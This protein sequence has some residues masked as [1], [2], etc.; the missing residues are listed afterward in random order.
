MSKRKSSQE[1]KKI[2]LD[3]ALRIVIEQGYNHTGIQEIVDAVGIPKGSF[4]NYFDSKETFGS[5]LVWHYAN[6]ILSQ[7]EFAR[8]DKSLDALSSLQNL[9]RLMITMFKEKYCREGCLVGNLAAELADTN[10]TIRLQLVDVF[11][12]WQKPVAE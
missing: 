6:Q 7:L 3:A 11:V 5:E 2:L 8:D 12:A 9:F 10:E 1:N 4:Y